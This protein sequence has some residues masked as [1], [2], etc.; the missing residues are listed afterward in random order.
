MEGRSAERPNRVMV[1]G[2]VNQAH[3]S[4]EGRSAERPNRCGA[5][6]FVQQLQPSM[7]GRSAERPN[8]LVPV[9]SPTAAQVLQWR[10]AQ[11]SGRTQTYAPTTPTGTGCLQWRAA[12]LSGRTS[13]AESTDNLRGA[14]N[15]GPLS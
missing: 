6:W 14:F 9:N 13:G 1:A 11:L 4:M 7:E 3:P 5:G 8:W 10:A 12:Q 2:S 15:G